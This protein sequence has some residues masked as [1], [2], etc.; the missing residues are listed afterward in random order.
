MG[1][2]FPCSISSLVRLMAS[3]KS[4]LYMS[5]NGVEGGIRAAFANFIRVFKSEQTQSGQLP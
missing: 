2:Q 4:H 5:P 3:G 1:Q